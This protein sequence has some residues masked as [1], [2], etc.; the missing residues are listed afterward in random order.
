MLFFAPTRGLIA[1]WALRRRQRWQFAGEMLLV[2]L[3]HHEGT[4]E[5]ADE[6]SLEHL[7]RHM[8]WSRAFGERVVGRLTRNDLVRRVDGPCLQLTDRG[9]ELAQKVMLR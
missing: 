6:C 5:E 3:S 9:R 2:H 8:K 7:G 1:R 4:P